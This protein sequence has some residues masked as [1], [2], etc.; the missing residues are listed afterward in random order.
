MSVS[1]VNIDI[2]SPVSKFLENSSTL[3]T[4]PSTFFHLPPL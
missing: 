1:C 3:E 2:F 4:E